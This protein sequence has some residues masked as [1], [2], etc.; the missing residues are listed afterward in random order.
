MIFNDDAEVNQLVWIKRSLTLFYMLYSSSDLTSVMFLLHQL[1]ISPHTAFTET[2]NSA[3]HICV[4]DIL[5]PVHLVSIDVFFLKQ[6]NI[7]KLL[8]LSMFWS[9]WISCE[10]RR[11]GL[12]NILPSFILFI[13]QLVGK[14]SHVY[15]TIK[16]LNYM[17]KKVSHWLL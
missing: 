15:Y 16:L 10:K 17:T 2:V 8:T 5:Y 14:W 3:S 4:F 9:L 6:S 12:A 1:H 13:K 7:S 11:E